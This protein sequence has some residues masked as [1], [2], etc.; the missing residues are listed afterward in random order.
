MAD[1]T[2]FEMLTGGNYRETITPFGVLVC[3]ATF[4]MAGRDFLKFFRTTA[5]CS[6]LNLIAACRILYV[7]LA[8]YIRG[9]EHTP[10]VPLSKVT[11]G[12]V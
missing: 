11:A 6:K 1:A 9:L 2:K 4:Q 5:E 7:H 8:P 3:D 10:A 12:P